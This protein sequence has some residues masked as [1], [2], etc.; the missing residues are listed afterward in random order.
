[1]RNRECVSKGMKETSDK[2]AYGLEQGQENVDE[3]QNERNSLIEGVE[4]MDEDIQES[5]AEA[6]QAIL[7]E[8]TDAMNREV[9]PEIDEASTTADQT[10]EF[11]EEKKEE[12][13]QA[14]NVAS[15]IH[16]R[17]FGKGA[18]QT[19]KTAEE[20]SKF[21]E[22][23]SYDISDLKEEKNRQFEAILNELRD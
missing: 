22:T 21:F 6:G 12:G 17:R 18:E 8:A 14:M 5:A 2:F 7:Q 10:S 9:R 23:A 19:Y 15:E 16:K 1:M 13:L 20:S 3:Y 4:G 11:S